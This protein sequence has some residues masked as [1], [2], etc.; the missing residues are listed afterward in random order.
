MKSR[1][2]QAAR[3]WLLLALLFALGLAIWWLH[4]SGRAAPAPASLLG[5][6]FSIPWAVAAALVLGRTDLAAFEP[7]A[8][9]DGRIRDLARRVA[10]RAEPA[11]SPRRISSPSSMIVSSMLYSSLRGARQSASLWRMNS[12]MPFVITREMKVRSEAFPGLCFGIIRHTRATSSASRSSRSA[13]LSACASVM[14][15][16]R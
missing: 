5:A 6:K 12:E 13:S 1:Y 2:W 10:V 14:A 3:F 7:P 15:R 4:L 8:L 16:D 11:M 9:G